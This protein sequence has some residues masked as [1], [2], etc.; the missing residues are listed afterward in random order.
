MTG[1]VLQIDNVHTGERMC[2]RACERGERRLW[3]EERPERVAGIVGRRSRADGKEN[4]EDP[5]RKA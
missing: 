5:N 4:A 2:A 1:R 3:R